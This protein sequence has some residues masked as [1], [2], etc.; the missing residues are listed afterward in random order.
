MRTATGSATV[1]TVADGGSF[2][3]WRLISRQ[4]ANNRPVEPETGH[5]QPTH[6]AIGPNNPPVVQQPSSASAS[7]GSA[8]PPT[9]RPGTHLASRRCTEEQEVIAAHTPDCN[10]GLELRNHP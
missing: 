7:P 3:G 5:T 4:P 6:P 8:Q 10:P 2:G 1:S 9:T